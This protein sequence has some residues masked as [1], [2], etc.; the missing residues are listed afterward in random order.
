MGGGVVIRVVIEV[1]RGGGGREGV[2]KMLMG[3]KMGL[4]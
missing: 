3:L 4:V 2:K 1:A